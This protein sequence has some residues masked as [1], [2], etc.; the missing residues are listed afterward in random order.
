MKAKTK[1]VTKAEMTVATSVQ[2]KVAV[3]AAKVNQR[4]SLLQVS[5]NKLVLLSTNFVEFEIL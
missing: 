2:M 5:H 1:A 3:I 4:K